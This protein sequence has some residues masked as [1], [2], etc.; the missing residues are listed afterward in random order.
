MPDQAPQE[1][2]EFWGIWP[3][4]RG[5]DIARKA[6]GKLTNAERKLAKDRCRAWVK[7]WRKANPQASHI[8]ASTYLNQRRFLDMAEPDKPRGDPDEFY[9]A[10]IRDGRR[11]VVSGISQARA[12]GMIERGLVTR[13]QCRS[14]GLL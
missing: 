12:A 7:D 5:K 9:A 2:D 14:V 11:Y 1:F 4:K 8:L 6:W 3:D 13:E 10:A